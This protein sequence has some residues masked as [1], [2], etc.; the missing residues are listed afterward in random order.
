MSI[1][2]FKFRVKDSVSSKHL[3]RYAIA[4]NYVWNFCV[5]TQRE[6]E[7][8][9]K[10]GKTL[11]WPT[12]FDLI[13]L[14]TGVSVELGL[15][16][17]TVQAICR[18]FT[19]SRDSFRKCPRFRSSFG[20][21]RSLGFVPFINRAVKIDGSIALYLKR[22]FKFWKSREIEGKYKAG[23]FIEDASGRWYIT[24]QCEVED[25][26]P[27]GKAKIGIDL[28]LKSLATTSAGQSISNLRHYRQYEKQL[29]VA[30]RAKNK[31]RVRAIYRK[32]ANA[33][34]YHLNI[35]STKLAIENNF[36]AIGNV[37]SA[38][39]AKTKMAKSILDAGWSIFKHMLRYKLARRQAVY[40]EVNEQY[41][42]Q[43]C[44]C[45]R[46]IPNS[47][48]KGMGALGIRQWECCECGTV[49]DRD[50]NAAQN[51]LRVGLERQALAEEILV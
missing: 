30:Q 50:V 4:C 15:H 49:H 29:G 37:S 41:T 33:R 32:I 19:I 46:K 13:K 45:C 5:A 9:R 14:T 39:L 36:I 8:R 38:K 7:N 6:T 48:P 11:R 51:I 17:D 34:N 1:I 27:S 31:R 22:K 44:S 40:V 42:S 35:V 26:L 20:T 47:S 18:Q 24:F 12:D 28:G 10:S 25:N 16:S 43:M 3:T 2:T 21:K 23:A